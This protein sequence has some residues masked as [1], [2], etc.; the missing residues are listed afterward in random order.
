MCIH[1]F[2]LYARIP[3][4]YSCDLD[5]DPMT[6]I[7]LCTYILNLK[8]ENE[9]SQSRLS[10]LEHEQDRHRRTECIKTATFAGGKTL[11]NSHREWET[12]T[13]AF[14]IVDQS[15]MRCITACIRS[16]NGDNTDVNSQQFALT[17]QNT[18]PTNVRYVLKSMAKPTWTWS[19][20]YTGLW[21]T[22]QYLA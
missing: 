3:S 1:V 11:Y 19:I 14:I 17:A 10:E 12:S 13:A 22:Q 6:L 18:R 21:K 20:T 2:S 4:F 9:V 5:T 15:A 7:S 16:C 8:T